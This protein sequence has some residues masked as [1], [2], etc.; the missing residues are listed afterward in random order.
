MK[1]PSKR[2]D[3]LGNK[4]KSNTETPKSQEAFQRRQLKERQKEHPA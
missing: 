4:N 1:N 3:H 2:A